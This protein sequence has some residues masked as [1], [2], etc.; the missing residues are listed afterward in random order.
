MSNHQLYSFRRCPYAIRAR[1]ALALMGISV[2][3]IEVKLSNKPKS[4]LELSAKGTVPVLALSNGQVIDES[5]D[6]IDW[7][8]QSSRTELYFDKT[9]ELILLNDFEFKQ[10]LDK[11]KY[12]ERHLE[13]TQSEHRDACCIYIKII[14]DKLSDSTFLM[15][16]DFSLID[17]A[18]M[19]F[20]RQFAYVDYDWF[21]ISPFT[22]VRR[23][24]KDWLANET[25]NLI[26][27][28]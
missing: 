2:D 18:I 26:M 14:E 4:L 10:N 1:L 28:K 9:N 11:Y 12:F 21:D 13:K 16:D 5:L 23:W 17:I 24:L 15:G 20:I 25:F 7:A 6:I 19:P 27:Q 22:N 3:I 8:C